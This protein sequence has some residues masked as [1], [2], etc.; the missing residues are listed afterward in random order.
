M[1]HVWGFL[2]WFGDGGWSTKMTTATN[3]TTAAIKVV[4]QQMEIFMA[5]GTS[6]ANPFIATSTTPARLC[7]VRPQIPLLPATSVA[8][9]F[10]ETGAS[11]FNLS[12]IEKVFG[13]TAYGSLA[14]PSLLSGVHFLKNLTRYPALNG[15][16]MTMLEGQVITV[17]VV[18]CFVLVFLIREWV[19]QQQPGIN[20]GAGF[21]VEVAGE[22]AARIRNNNPED[23]VAAGGLRV[24]PLRNGGDVVN[25]AREHADVAARPIAR[26]RRRVI[27]NEDG[28]D[29]GQRVPAREVEH[30]G[31]M[32]TIDRNEGA[33]LGE[34]RPTS[35][36]NSVT[37]PLVPLSETS[38]PLELDTEHLP[39]DQQIQDRFNA[40]E[41]VSVWRRAG[42]DP[43]EVLRIIDEEGL[44]E[45]LGHWKE[46]LLS[47]AENGSKYQAIENET[48][49]G[50]TPGPL[51][52]G[53]ADSVNARPSEDTILDSSWKGKERLVESSP[54][55]L[56][57]LTNK[58]AINGDPS[59]PHPSRADEEPLRSSITALPSSEANIGSLDL[60]KGSTST[61]SGLASAANSGWSF[62]DVDQL[63]PSVGGNAFTFGSS[64]KPS[65]EEEAGQS[66]AYT[67]TMTSERPA[68]TVNDR[69]AS[70][71]FANGTSATENDEDLIEI[72]NPDTGAVRVVNSWDE[73][74]ANH[75]VPDAIVPVYGEVEGA[76]ASDQLRVHQEPANGAGRV[77]DME[78]HRHDPHAPQGVL[79][80]VA[81]FLWGDVQTAHEAEDQDDEHVVQNIDAEAPFVPV[82]HHQDHGIFD[83]EESDD[84]DDNQDGEVLAAALAAGIDPNDPDGLDDAEDF[85]GIMELVGMRGPFMA[86][87]QNGIFSAVLI[88]LTVACGVWI[89]Y[90]I[91]RFVLLLIAN[92]SASVKLPLKFL[93]VLATFVQDLAVVALG[94]LSYLMI[95]LYSIL[96]HLYRP[97]ISSPVPAGLDQLRPA[98]ESLQL[99][100]GAGGRILEGIVQVLS[101]IPDS[102][103]PAFSATS[104]EALLQIK[105]LIHGALGYSVEMVGLIMKQPARVLMSAIVSL[106]SALGSAKLSGSLVT[107]LSQKIYSLLTS[108]DAW[109]ISLDMPPRALPVDPALS[110]WG[111]WD[112]FWAI[113]TGYI[114]LT[115]LGAMYL[116]K[117][118][119]FSTGQVGREWEAIIIDVLN[120]A[121][122]VMKV[123][124]IISIEMLVFPLYCGLLLDLALLPLFANASI[125]SRIYFT[126]ECPITSIFVHWFVGTCYM[127]HFAL[128]V[129]MC[130]KIMRNGVLYFIRDPD[131]P[132]FHPVRDVLER[133]VATQLRKIMFSAMVYGALVVICLGGVVWGL[134]FGFPSVLP[135]HWSSN[136]PVLEFP[137]DLLFYNFFMP[138]AVR[139]FKP[140]DGLHTMYAWWFRQCA[141]ILRLTWFLFG[142]RRQEEEGHHV[143]RTWMGVIKGEQGDVADTVKQEQV[144]ELLA[145]NLDQKAYFVRDG[146]FVRAP[147]SDQVRIPKGTKVFLEVDEA[148]VPADGAKDVEDGLHGRNTELFKMVYI[149]PHF[150]FRI[151][152]FILSIWAFAAITGISIT[153]VPLVCG[154]LIFAK[155]LPAHVATN[156][157]YA[158]SIGIYLLGSAFYAGFHIRHLAE[159][160][161]TILAVDTQTPAMIW[162]RISKGVK[163]CFRVIFV[164]SSFVLVLPTLFAFAVELYFI[165][166]LHT[167]FAVSEPHTIHFVQSWTLGLLY[168]KLTTRFI[169]WNQDSRPAEALRAVTRLGYLNPDV[170]IATRAF[171]LPATTCLTTALLAPY[172]LAKAAEPFEYFAGTVEKRILL[173]RYAYPFCFAMI[174]SAMALG[175]VLQVVKAWQTTIRDEVY[176]IGERLHNFGDR[177]R[178][179]SAALI[180]ASNR[181]DT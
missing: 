173:F 46:T 104:H 180:P 63:S 125:R 110:Y 28:P 160:I 75:P 114:A 14:Q 165:L 83:N 17:I 9:F 115:L 98:L 44:G 81:H 40:R 35:P 3:A 148:N 112:R 34:Q 11:R 85:E 91:G 52:D 96:K 135:I 154:R 53:I 8:T 121:G 79:G 50:V 94:T 178:S 150:R 127:F 157:I 48:A 47:S 49:N 162:N 172:C 113:L 136:E 174:M 117:G 171:I 68:D 5:Q 141:R 6:P 129:S 128:F 149:P 109:V 1:R 99:A 146:K 139:F 88:S 90:N 15:I 62:H 169:L 59:N 54:N 105:A 26:P 58:Q 32:T 123:I 10:N 138:L 38:R 156:D 166:P 78:Q 159:R 158:F 93:F 76:T 67:T 118:S 126:L 179:H 181:I 57:D 107:Y 16:I 84:E 33:A 151:F 164:Y 132:T 7:A 92:P 71:I 39:D 175:M 42:G 30:H 134:A 89:P 20:M 106:S 66:E 155:L 73:E 122:G 25:I 74:F 12:N 87:I 176:L 27:R 152:F 161:R 116:R 120:Q 70:P 31:N 133:N 56:H 170:K 45:Q 163:Q 167:Y 147:A 69:Q 124:L 29:H 144:H 41:F 145:Q 130:R 13:A 97:G 108:P 43:Q 100:K 55:S 18:V 142:Q 51:S 111:G 64:E 119:P 61:Y 95:Q 131:D 23:A 140:S 177:G 37:G 101:Q 36:G 137:I 22:R 103:V 80:N 4:T 153:I 168:V 60:V 21:N 72:F 65:P 102:E 82:G 86:L 2:F 77:N 143:R 19:V 24:N